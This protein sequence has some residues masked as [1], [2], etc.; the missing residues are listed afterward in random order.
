MP[1]SYNGKKIVPA[2]LVVINK[3]YISTDD[4]KKLGLNYEI[5]LNGTM[6]PFRGSPSGN[7]SSLSNAF[8]ILSG[9]PPDEL[10]EGNNEDFNHL[11]RK[12][13]AL[14]FL[15]SVDGESLEW[16]PTQG[17]PVVKCNPKV[18]S[19]TFNEGIWAD[20]CD[21]T[22]T[23]LAERIYIPTGPLDQEDAPE[24]E[25]VASASE[26][27]S[28]EEI[29]GRD[30]D[31]Y[32]LTHTVTAKGIITYDEL[33]NL[34][35]GNEAWEN[36]KLWVDARA[37]GT[38][39]SDVI[40]AALGSTR[41][42]GGF[43]RNIQISE[44]DGTYTVTEIYTLL[45]STTFTEK[46]FTVN[47]RTANDTIDVS[48]NGKIFG[49]SAGESTG[50][51]TAIANAK[52]AVPTDSAAR[53]EAL[54]AVSAFLDGGTIASSPSQKNI[55]INNQEGSVTFSFQ[56]T[57]D[58]DE[59]VSQSCVSSLAFDSSTGKYGLSLTCDFEGK[60]EDKE[61]RLTNAKAAIL[62]EADAL[63]LALDLIGTELPVEVT[64]ENPP[65]NRT[66]A[67]NEGRGSVR[68]SFS[69]EQINDEFGN[70]EI[71]VQTTF[72]AAVTAQIPIPGRAEGPVIQDMSTF[73]VQIVTVTLAS[74]NNTEKPDNSTIISVM[75]DAGGILPTWFLDSDQENFDVVTKNYQRT[76]RHIVKD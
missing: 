27:W 60:G 54:A 62:D 68:Q 13:E 45:P 31:G 65:N 3:N 21:Y 6:I 43:T 28:F 24:V 53:T 49:I 19:I 74:K 4:Q 11:L 52:A 9:D 35:A 23:L 75:D 73:T 59:T 42:G 40:L 34:L 10:F 17:Q 25:F 70:F 37:T 58:E 50:G 8:W 15:F 64:I 72:P 61:E 48:Y 41:I 20:R 63:T 36:A 30:S 39:D 26:E 2:P 7:Y 67:I 69:W 71:S 22:I 51:D 32:R 56:W 29:S 55:A 38:I 66:T 44:T 76:R 12:Q 5:T 57:A 14:R 16:Q 47:K 33:G 18:Q 1:L 46:N